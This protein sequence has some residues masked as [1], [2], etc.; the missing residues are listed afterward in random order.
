MQ[1]DKELLGKFNSQIKSNVPHWNEGPSERTI[2]NAT[3][4][5]D[6]TKALVEC[7]R[8]EFGLEFSTKDV[9]VFGK[10]DSRILTGS[11]KIRPAVE[12]IEEAIRSGKLRGGQTIFEATSGNFG[13][14]LGLLRELDINVIAL[15]SRKLQDGVVKDLRDKGAKL[16]NL[17]IDICPAPGLKVDTNTLVAKSV[18]N[19]VREQLAELGLDD[20]VFDNS[21]GE[22]ERLLGRQD[23]I[24]LARVL[25]RIYGGF[26]PEQYDNQLNVKSHETV[27][28]PEVDQQ[29]GAMGHSLGDFRILTAFGTGGTSTGLSSYA[30]KKYGKKL[31]HVVFPLANQDVAGI[32]SREKALGLRFYQPV[33]YGGQHE[34]DFEAAKL[35]HR[36]FAQKGYDIGES[37]ALVL[38]SCIQMLNFGVG[39]KFV[40]LIADGMDKYRDT[41][42]AELETTRRYEVTLEEASSSL[43]D[44]S[45]VLWTHTMFAPRDEGIKLIASSLGCDESKIKVARA[46]DIDALISTQQIPQT[47]QNLIATD[48]PKHLLVCMVGGTSFAVAQLLAKK[49]IQAESLIGGIVNLSETRGKQPPQL[50]QMATE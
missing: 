1:V 49:G 42:K 31:V 12:I 41:V 38:Y 10:F 34:V 35:V 4:L 24:G 39:D 8:R 50:V 36:F 21:R 6:I 48:K 43:A 16:V 9:K 5:E 25:A 45:E 37:S 11:V 13:I 32:R 46:R 27:T 22:I 14:A 3:P 2:N 19:N 33:L 28:G 29:L 18:A 23:V 20:S 17:D 15:V 7:A 26:C 47:L 44:Y 40:V 30:S